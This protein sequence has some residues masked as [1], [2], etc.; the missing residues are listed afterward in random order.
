MRLSNQ[1]APPPPL[2][3]DP[4]SIPST[5]TPPTTTAPQ[6]Q[7]QQ[8]LLWRRQPSSLSSGWPCCG[9]TATGASIHGSYE[10]IRLKRKEMWR[11]FPLFI[12]P[13]PANNPTTT[14][15]PQTPTGNTLRPRTWSRLMHRGRCG[16]RRAGGCRWCCPRPPWRRGMSSDTR[17]TMRPRRRRRVGA[18]TWTRSMSRRKKGKGGNESRPG[19]SPRWRR[20]PMNH[21]RRWWRTG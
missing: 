14:P 4:P 18:Y 6:L 21:P 13:I 16:R 5:P 20:R 3:L 12:Q 11:T 17:S 1:S 15:N 8:R 9:S 2:F 19:S 10:S 7:L